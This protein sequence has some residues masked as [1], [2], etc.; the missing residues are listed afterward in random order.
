MKETLLHFVWQY[1]HFNIRNLF[2]E[3]GD[4]LQIIRQ[5]NYQH[6]A[7]PDFENCQ[8]VIDGIK[9]VGNIEIHV[10]SSDW[11]LHK[12]HQNPAFDTVILHVVW[13]HD[14]EIVNSK[15]N[16]IPV[17][18]LKGRVKPD[19]F[20][21]YEKLI[22]G[23]SDILCSDEIVD[24]PKIRKFELIDKAVSSR[25]Q[26]KSSV[27]LNRLETNQGDWEETAY[28]TL[29][30]YF[31]FKV[32]NDSFLS[33]AQKLPYKVIKKHLDQ[34][35]QV[36]ALLFG[37]AGFLREDGD[38]HMLALYQEYN[39]LAKKYQLSGKE[40]SPQ[41]WRF[42]R[43]RPANFPTVRIAQLVSLLTSV[44]NLFSF[45]IDDQPL[46][47]KRGRFRQQQPEYWRHHYHFGKRYLNKTTKTIGKQSVESLLINVVTPI[48]AAYSRY[49]NQEIYMNRAIDLLES[50]QPEN[51]KITRQWEDL[52]FVNGS[53][54][55]SQGLI[56]HY[57]EFCL[58]KRCLRCIAGTHIIKG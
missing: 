36:E 44:N 32:N 41:Q 37:V 17:L 58:E 55:D 13:D 8:V 20:T 43:L 5:G 51:N 52:G 35:E 24:L 50:L 9:L 54:F 10:K 49:L 27:I 2:T 3:S 22:N 34:P 28:Q 45:L 33:L 7:G 16:Q 57:N 11:M 47:E 6:D 42:L 40:L 21:R 31:G 39:F 14:R 12:H 38:Q 26:Q 4:E 19:L 25:L 18:V 15:G 1:L 30:Q 53:A 48:M 56:M 23:K 29:L 46:N